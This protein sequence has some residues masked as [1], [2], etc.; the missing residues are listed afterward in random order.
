MKFDFSKS[1]DTDFRNKLSINLRQLNDNVLYC[2]RELNKCV[3][4]LNAI[5]NSINLQKQVDEYFDEDK[6]ETSP[7]TEQVT[8][9]DT[10]RSSD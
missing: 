8:N 1:I 10:N 3:K 2:T 6:E 9:L 7:Q 5:N 4:M